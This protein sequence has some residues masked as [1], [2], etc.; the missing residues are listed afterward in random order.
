M[1]NYHLTAIIILRLVTINFDW[2]IRNS[3]ILELLLLLQK[4]KTF[5]KKYFFK[6]KELK[7]LKIKIRLGLA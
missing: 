2:F 7:F 1:W 3:R 4:I 6:V 5:E